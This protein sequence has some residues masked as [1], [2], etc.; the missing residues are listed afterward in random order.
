MKSWNFQKEH[1]KY[2]VKKHLNKTK[3]TWQIPFVKKESGIKPKP[4]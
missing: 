4:D 2:H 1:S 3:V